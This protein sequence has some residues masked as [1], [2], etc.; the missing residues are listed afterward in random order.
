MSNGI[1]RLL[2]VLSNANLWDGN[3]CSEKILGLMVLLKSTRQGLWPRVIPR[4]KANIILILIH[5]F[6]V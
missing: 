4:K 2:I 6:P 3:G 1:G 5:Q